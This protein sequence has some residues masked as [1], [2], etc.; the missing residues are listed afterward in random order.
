MLW[1]GSEDF[2][3]DGEINYLD[4]NTDIMLMWA[5]DNENYLRQDLTEA[6]ANR[7]GGAGVYYHISYWG[8]PSSYLWLNSASLFV[9]TEQ[10][11]RAYNIGADDYWILNVGDIKPSEPS[12][13]YFLKMAWDPAS[14]DGDSVGEYLTAQ[15]IRDYNL[16]EEDAKAMADAICEY[17]VINGSIRKAE[18]Y[19]DGDYGTIPVAFS[20]VGNGDEGLLWLERLTSLVD[21]VDALYQ[22]MSDECKISFYE[23]FYYNILSCLDIA[24]S[25][26]TTKRTSLQPS[27]EDWEVQTCTRSL[28]WRLCK[29]QR[30][31]FRTSTPLTTTS[32]RHLWTI[33]TPERL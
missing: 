18:F 19:A 26:Y 16:S 12:M 10:M 25:L 29:G 1:D 24:S 2:N 30:T 32:G 28:P 33:S 4:D 6:E 13:E 3:G 9:M 7:P 27:R 11:S 15:A 17:Y 8:P 22:K 31:D 20:V 14:F 5:E 21:T 23:H